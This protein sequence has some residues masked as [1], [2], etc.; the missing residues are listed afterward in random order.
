MRDS[1]TC[2]FVKKVPKFSRKRFLHSTSERIL[3]E[4]LNLQVEVKI[5][6]SKW[7]DKNKMINTN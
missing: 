4:T 5:R 3:L 2:V 7:Y 1:N 6:A